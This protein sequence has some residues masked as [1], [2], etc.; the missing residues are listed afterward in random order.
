VKIGCVG[1]WMVSF[2]S[3]SRT[4]D[5]HG[6]LV[7]DEGSVLALLLVL[8]IRAA[9]GTWVIYYLFI[10]FS[11]QHYPDTR[12]RKITTH[13]HATFVQLKSRT[14]SFNNCL[15]L[16][17]TCRIHIESKN[18]DTVSLPAALRAAQCKPAGI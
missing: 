17:S 9:A 6:G 12:T 18:D 11:T 4:S 2:T 13:I 1:A 16:C 3:N 15:Y 7:A 8:L 14:F 5:I 10:T